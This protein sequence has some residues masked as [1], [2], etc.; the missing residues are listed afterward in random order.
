MLDDEIVVDEDKIEIKTLDARRRNCRFSW[1]TR[2]S[3]PPL[4]HL[5]MVD[6]HR[7]KVTTLAEVLKRSDT[8]SEAPLAAS[9]NGCGGRI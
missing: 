1:R 2:T 8:P 3:R 4:L 5:E 9:S 6:P 7:Q